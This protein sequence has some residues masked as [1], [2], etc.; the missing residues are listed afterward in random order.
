MTGVV[1]Y[2]SNDI[3]NWAQFSGD[4]N[5]IH[6]DAA[7]SKRFGHASVV[8]HGMIA[9]LQALESVLGGLREIP[10][11]QEWTTVTQRLRIPIY[12]GEQLKLGPGARGPQR[13]ALRSEASV[14]VQV[15]VETSDTYETEVPALSCTATDETKQQLGEISV[16]PAAL[17]TGRSA[18]HDSFGWLR[19]DITFFQAS[20]F[21]H[22]MRVHIS[23]LE[24]WAQRSLGISQPT[25]GITDN[26]TYTVVQTTHR[27]IVHRS[28]LDDD[29]GSLENGLQLRF[30]PTAL[31]TLAGGGCASVCEIEVRADRQ[32]PM[33]AKIGLLLTRNT[34]G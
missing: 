22:F 13:L 23:T 11:S 20:A 27:A 25:L 2:S 17:A 31:T 12:P 15:D 1:Q 21:A 14:K 24:R 16:D 34:K 10:G 26:S 9:V 8:V 29:A 33:F 18:L 7:A 32:Y 4:Y 28:W 5:P 3:A 6:F 30:A 19:T